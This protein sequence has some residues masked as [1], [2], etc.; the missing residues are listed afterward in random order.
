GPYTSPLY[1]TYSNGQTNTQT[2][3][4]TLNGFCGTPANLSLGATS[5]NFG[6][7]LLNT[8]GTATL[9]VTNTGQS[10]ATAMQVAPLNQYFGASGCPS[11][12]AG[13]PNC[14]LNLTF[15]P[16]VEAPYAGPPLFLT[17]NNGV[18]STTSGSAVLFGNGMGPDN[19]SDGYTVGM[20]DC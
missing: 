19:D 1:L 16:T 8:T 6:N 5:V 10:P 13:G 14:T 17:Y 11:T 12:L 3:V 18:T 4:L 20:G 9:S 2:A 15:T 7:V